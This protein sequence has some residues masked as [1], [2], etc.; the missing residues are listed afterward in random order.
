MS[1]ALREAKWTMRPASWAG[2]SKLF[3]QTVNGP[4][5]TSAVPQ[6]GQAAGIRQGSCALAVGLLDPLDHLGDDVA[7]AL[8][9][10]PVALA[11]VL[12]RHL[13]AVVQ[14]G[15]G[16]GDAADLD[17]QHD[18]DRGDH[19]G[20]ADAGEDGE[21]AGDLLARRELEGEGPARMAGGPAQ[22]L[23]GGEVVEL[24]DDAVDLEAEIVALGFEIGVVG[25]D[26]VQG[27]DAP[28]QAR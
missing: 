14:G 24:D 3:G 4:R 5:S 2:H 17:R 12:P 1:R 6:E 23:A 15:A 18:G 10:H 9:A 21:D 20:A 22:R 25:Q 8:D 27:A 28:H 11:D 16:D 19:A 7:G 13:L 26:L